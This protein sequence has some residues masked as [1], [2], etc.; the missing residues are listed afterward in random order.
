MIKQTEGKTERLGDAN[1]QMSEL[2]LLTI[3]IQEEVCKETGTSLEAFDSNLADSITTY[4]LSRAGMSIKDTL[5]V[6][7][8]TDK[9][10]SVTEVDTDGTRKEII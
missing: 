6:T 3:I 10:R 2:A 9:C 4:R 1:L 7:G 5:D 8:L